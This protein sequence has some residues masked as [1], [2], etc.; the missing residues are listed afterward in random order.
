MENFVNT[1]TNEQVEFLKEH[2][3]IRL[4]YNYISNQIKAS[5]MKNKTK[6]TDKIYNDLS[7]LEKEF[8]KLHMDGVRLK[9]GK[10]EKLT[11]KEVELKKLYQ[12]IYA[13]KNNNSMIER[14]PVV[15][16]NV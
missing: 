4:D 13:I 5:S 7:S 6:D 12:K 1:L 8:N 11:D 10:L 2:G 16:K 14:K 3:S 15:N 9:T